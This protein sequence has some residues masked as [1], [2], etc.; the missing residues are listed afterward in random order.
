MATYGTAFLTFRSSV[1]RG[2]P[3]LKVENGVAF[4]SKP[5]SIAKIVSSAV[6]QGA[7]VICL[8]SAK[9]GQAQG[10]EPIVVKTNQKLVFTT[11]HPGC[12]VEIDTNITLEA[13]SVF[14]ANNI[15]LASAS[16]SLP[17]FIPSTTNPP[18]HTVNADTSNNNLTNVF[19]NNVSLY[20]AV[21]ENTAPVL[22]IFSNM[23]V[24]A[25]NLT[26]VGSSFTA[27]PL[28]LTAVAKC[29]DQAS[30][31]NFNVLNFEETGRGALRVTGYCKIFSEGNS[32]VSILAKEGNSELFGTA[33]TWDINGTIA[34]QGKHSLTPYQDGGTSQDQN[35]PG[36]FMFGDIRMRLS[37]LGNNGL[38]LPSITFDTDFNTFNAPQ[39]IFFTADLIEVELNGPQSVTGG[40]II[41][42]SHPNGTELDSTA[43]ENSPSLTIRIGR[44]IENHAFANSAGHD[45]FN[46]NGTHQINGVDLDIVVVDDPSSN[47][48]LRGSFN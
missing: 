27:A 22:N 48:V 47:G 46:N 17:V 36:K 24:E 30:A 7:H 14:E 1:E 39:S 16:Q 8:P 35:L 20:G 38:Q 32:K 21:N 2:D 9:Y 10:D 43:D 11:S 4:V 15:T 34:I 45:Q 41:F 28:Q 3:T 19:L 6:K 37:N 29:V 31:D 26:I 18:K 5:G 42:V 25:S 40:S 12:T 13:G 44:Y 23:F 33:A